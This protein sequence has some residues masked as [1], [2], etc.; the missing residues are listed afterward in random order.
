MKVYIVMGSCGEYSDRTEWAVAWYSDE[1]IAEKHGDL[2]AER[3]FQIAKKIK[4]KD[5]EP[6]ELENEMPKNEY[7]PN[8]KW[9]YTGTGYY[10]ISVER[11]W[12]P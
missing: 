1:K 10:V 7:D 12:L 3:S 5:I 11:G 6:C 9:S 2:A 4:E 8:M